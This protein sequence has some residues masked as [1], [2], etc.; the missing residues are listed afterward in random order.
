MFASSL[1]AAPLYPEPILYFEAPLHLVQWP[2]CDSNTFSLTDRDQPDQRLSSSWLHWRRLPPFVLF[3]V[4]QLPQTHYGRFRLLAN[5]DIQGYPDWASRQ[6]IPVPS[7]LSGWSEP[8][9]AETD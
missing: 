6:R 8:K 1:F 2:R 4:D 7:A 5:H 3:V 9:I